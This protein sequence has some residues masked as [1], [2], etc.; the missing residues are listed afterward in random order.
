[1]EEYDNIELFQLALG[2]IEPWKVQDVNLSLEKEK[3]DIYV[4]HTRGFKFTCTGCKD[5]HSAHDTIS[6]TWKHLNFFQYETYLH[7]SVPRIR[8][9]KC[10]KTSTVP[11]PWARAG[12]GFTLL[13]EAF[14]MELSRVMAISMVGLTIGEHDTRIMRVV[15]H[16]VHNTREKVDMSAVRKIGVDETSEKKGHNYITTFVDLERECV[17]YAT[18]GKDSTT[19]KRFTKDLQEHGGDATHIQTA[20]IDLSPAY[21]KGVTDYLPEATITYDHFHVIG[22][23][24]EAVDSVRREES[25]E[26]EILKHSRYW[27]LKNPSNL[28]KKQAEKLQTMSDM[29]LKTAKAYRIKLSLQEIY[30]LKTAEEALRKWYYW[31]THSQILAIIKVAKTIK[32]HWEGIMN[33]FRYKATNGIVECFN[34]IIQTIKRRA[35]GYR[36]TDNFITMVYLVKGKLNFNLP[37]VTGLTHYK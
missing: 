5:T 32:R 31:A 25:K 36:N 26:Q 19:I 13:L 18:K 33:Y 8:C 37:A 35:R 4:H 16:H 20:A 22:L 30:K 11:V 10:K 15:T 1:M 23:V 34:G 12:S 14:T 28:K 3:L 21:T 27:W 7:C 6:R 29:N 9:T 24:N 2:L 17:L